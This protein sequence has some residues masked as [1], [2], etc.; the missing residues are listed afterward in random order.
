MR[1][2]FVD[3]CKTPNFALVLV[4][5]AESSVV[6]VRSTSLSLRMKG[7]RRIHFKNESD[8][9]RKKILRS[10]AKLD[11][12]LYIFES[13]K[14]SHFDARRSCLEALVAA[15]Q[16]LGVVHLVFET[17]E[18]IV[19]LDAEVLR[20]SNIRFRHSPAHQEPCLWLPD[21]YAW[22]NQRGSHWLSFLNDRCFTKVTVD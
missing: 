3:E 22:A 14:K 10:Y 16:N 17:D 4:L 18:S 6:D 5:V 13:R 15:S 9:R 11:V 8:S 19:K 12:D 2:G 7:Q 21:A 20:N 1:V